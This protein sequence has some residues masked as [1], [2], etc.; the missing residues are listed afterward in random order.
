MNAWYVVLTDLPTE[1]ADCQVMLAHRDLRWPCDFPYK[2]VVMSPAKPSTYPL[3][4]YELARTCTY[5][6]MYH[7]CI[8][9]ARLCIRLMYIYVE[10][11]MCRALDEHCTLWSNYITCLCFD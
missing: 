9:Y 6:C 5:S 7:V 8:L 1:R 11:R 10:I 2:V 4:S 3:P